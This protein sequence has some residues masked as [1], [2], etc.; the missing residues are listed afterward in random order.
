[1][2]LIS[3]D[4]LKDKGIDLDDSTIW[5][6]MRAGEFPKAVIVGNRRSWVES[7]IDDYIANLIAKRDA[8]SVAA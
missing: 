8:T 7:E 3:K 4:G 2:K 6:K 1:M 5:R